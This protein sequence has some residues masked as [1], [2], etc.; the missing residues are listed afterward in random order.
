MIIG[1]TQRTRTVSESDGSAGGDFFAIDIDVATQTTAERLHPM[2]FRLQPGGTAIV[3]PFDN[4]SNP[5]L[6]ALFGTK[7]ESNSPIEE[8]FDLNRL[9]ATIPPRY[10]QIRDDLRPEPEE[11]F[12]I[13]IF[14]IDVLGRRELFSCNEDDSGAANYFCKTTISIIDDDGRFM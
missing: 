10:G 13:R 1:F 5:L 3:D 9:G 7:V 14:P 2:L 4:P 8:E 12:T 11:C 6:D